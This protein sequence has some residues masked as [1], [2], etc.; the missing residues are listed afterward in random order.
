[1]RIY[2]DFNALAGGGDDCALL[3]HCAGTLKDLHRLQIRLK[4]GDTYTFW[5]RSDMEEDLEVD[6]VVM[7]DPRSKTWHAEFPGEKIRYVPHREGW[8]DF[9]SFPCFRCRSDLKQ[10]RDSVG[11]FKDAACPSCGLPVMHPIAPPG[12]P[13][14]KE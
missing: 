11:F 9:K 6:A 14:D 12:E 8:S 7:F 2:A 3:L 1:M 5:D 10:L 4:E 13:A